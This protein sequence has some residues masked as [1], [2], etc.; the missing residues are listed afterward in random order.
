MDY[1]AKMRGLLIIILIVL[2]APVVAVEVYKS[3]DEHGNTVFSDQP[4]SNA[5]KIEVPELPTVPG[6]QEIPPPRRAEPAAAEKYHT[7]VIT[8]PENDG[9]YWRGEGDVPV[10]IRTEPRLSAGDTIVLLLNGDEYASGRTSNFKLVEL[11]R[12]THQLSAIIRNAR[13]ETIKSTDSVTFHIK[14]PSI[15]HRTP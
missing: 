9:T 4:S 12:G 15:L 8:H 10:R 6:L 2:A 13:G 11:N 14:Q 5:E 7:M 1:A 3:V